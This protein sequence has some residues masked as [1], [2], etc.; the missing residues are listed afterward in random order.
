MRNLVTTL[1]ATTLG[2]LY[3][4]GMLTFEDDDTAAAFETHPTLPG[5]TWEQAIAAILNPTP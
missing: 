2:T 5:M 3:T 4:D 1:N